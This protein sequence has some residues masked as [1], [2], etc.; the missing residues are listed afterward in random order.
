MAVTSIA[1]FRML[2]GAWIVLLKCAIVSRIPDVAGQP[3]R[4]DRANHCETCGRQRLQLAA[5]PVDVIFWYSCVKSCHVVAAS[6]SSLWRTQQTHCFGFCARCD[7][8]NNFVHF[9]EGDQPR[10]G[11]VLGYMVGLL[12]MI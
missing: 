6:S 10:E 2:D 11:D 1:F 12:H 3:R 8:R 4:P 9:G 7:I 5:S